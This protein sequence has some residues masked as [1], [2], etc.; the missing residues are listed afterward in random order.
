MVMHYAETVFR[1]RHYVDFSNSAFPERIVA[2]RTT[3]LSAWAMG[4]GLESAMSLI[5]CSIFLD[6]AS[7]TA[8]GGLF[9]ISLTSF[10]VR[11]SL[12]R[13]ARE[14]MSMVVG[15]SNLRNNWE[16]LSAVTLV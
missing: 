10:R 4:A 16:P 7:W 14:E 12:I 11:A 3:V 15:P 9:A 13:E 8:P 5:S 6:T 2:Y 1:P